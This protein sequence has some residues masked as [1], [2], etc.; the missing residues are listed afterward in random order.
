MDLCK[1]IKI[2]KSI[3]KLWGGE[4]FALALDFLA[5]ELNQRGFIGPVHWKEKTMIPFYLDIGESIRVVLLLN[6]VGSIFDSIIFVASKRLFK[7][8]S[9]NEP[10]FEPTYPDDPEYWKGFTSCS[11]FHLAHTKWAQSPSD[12][13]PAWSMTLDKTVEANA[14]Q[15]LADFDLLQMPLIRKLRSDEELENA[16]TDVLNYTQPAW[17]KSNPPGGPYVREKLAALRREK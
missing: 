15:W 10:W 12:E 3:V 6:K 8:T 17:V 14:M 1:P 16:M 5:K 9:E 11:A 2:P 7:I 4:N 13:N